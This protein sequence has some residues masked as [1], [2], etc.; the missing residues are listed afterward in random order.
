MRGLIGCIIPPA[1]C[2]TSVSQLSSGSG[3]ISFSKFI[4]LHKSFWLLW[5]SGLFRLIVSLSCLVL[6]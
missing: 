2:I 4:F 1:W 5:D 3:S 6:L